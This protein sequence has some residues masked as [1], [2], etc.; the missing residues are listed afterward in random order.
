MQADRISMCGYRIVKPGKVNVIGS[1]PGFHYLLQAEMIYRF[2][3]RPAGAC[4]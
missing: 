3:K 4:S 2:I 1:L